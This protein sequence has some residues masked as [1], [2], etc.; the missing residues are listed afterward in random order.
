[1][2]PKGAQYIGDGVYVWQDPLDALQ[3][4]LGTEREGG[5]QVIALEWSVYDQL[6]A[7]ANSVWKRDA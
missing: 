7:F 3:I 4:W 2:P 1:M 6:V 5:W